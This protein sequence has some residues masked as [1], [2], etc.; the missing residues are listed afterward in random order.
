MHWLILTGEYPP[1]EG[2]VSDYTRGV[3][4]GL[5][6]R[7]ES[8]TVLAPDKQGRATR[9][10]TRNGVVIEW[11]PGNFGLRGQL[12]LLQ[13]LREAPAG[14]CLFVQYGPHAFGWKAM[15]IPLCFLLSRQH[16]HRLWIMFHEVAYPLLRGQPWRHKLLAWSNRGMA[17]I[18][19]NAS[20]RSLI[21][22]DSWRALLKSICGRDMK[23]EWS[24]VPS[25]FEAIQYLSPASG[26]HPPSRTPG[27]MN[28]GH[29][30]TFGKLIA[31]LL[32]PIILEIVERVPEAHVILI[33]RGGK[34]FAERLES[35]GQVPPGRITATGPLN[36]TEIAPQIQLCD[37]LI[38]PYSDGIS[39]RR[40]SAMAG[41]ALGMPMITQTGHLTENLWSECRA[42]QFVPD[43]DPRTWVEMA[44]ALIASPEERIKLGARARSLYQMRFSLEKTLDRLLKSGE[45]PA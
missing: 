33:G 6:R 5:V 30:G 29:F 26:P 10:E 18:L 31:D 23:A 40:G 14:S 25:N 24:P 38:Q 28:I 3:A 44:K 16:R 39:T 43:P 35:D 36:P 32:K 37:L 20:D 11:L 1:A 4:E 21:S 12:A 34:Q 2:G 45:G 15:N 13:A 17:R 9:R 27:R 7:G 19:A 42:V 8:V 41:L 22:T